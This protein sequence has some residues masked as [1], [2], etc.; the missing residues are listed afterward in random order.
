MDFASL[1]I[2]LAVV[3]FLLIMSKLLGKVSLAQITPFDFISA[4]VLGELVG[5]AIYDKEAQLILVIYS[6]IFMGALSY[7]VE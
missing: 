1:T 3:F 6:V 7:L 2:E 5:N 4:L